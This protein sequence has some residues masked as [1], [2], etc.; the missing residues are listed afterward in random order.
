MSVPNVH[1]CTHSDNHIWLAS[2]KV[3]AMPGLQ[4]PGRAP[5]A[6]LAHRCAGSASPG[7]R[8]AT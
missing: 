1:L 7:S 2:A 6:D 3:T 4:V 5:I 8:R